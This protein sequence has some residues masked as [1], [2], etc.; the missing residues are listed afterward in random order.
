MT[1]SEFR[2][3]NSII[4]GQKASFIATT[5]SAAPGS[6]G[7]SA[8]E[9]TAMSDA[10]DLYATT[11]LDFQAAQAAL[12]AAK[13][14]RDTQRE[15]MLD[16]FCAYLKIMYATPSVTDE[17]I[18]SLTLAIRDET[19]T[20]VVPTTPVDLLATPFADGTVTVS[21]KRNGNPYGVV[22]TVETA[23]ADA[24]HWTVLGNTTKAR[25]T[26][27]GFVPGVPRW[28]RVTASKNGIVSDPS[29]LAGIYIPSPV[30]QQEV[31]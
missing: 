29:F 20:P 7:L 2:L 21:W 17:S 16:T 27:S 25:E 5:V 4:L 13:A 11:L 15:A 10:S 9:A 22:F 1:L 23:E 18:A 31:A 24:T 3:L 8:T 26:Y 12:D 30:Q 14:A 19:R 6:F 28:F